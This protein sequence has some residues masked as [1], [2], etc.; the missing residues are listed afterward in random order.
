MRRVGEG[1]PLLRGRLRG[2]YKSRWLS[3]Q[4]GFFGGF[5][6]I[7]LQGSR[8]RGARRPTKVV[9][10]ALCAAKQ[11]WWLT[12]F[13]CPRAHSTQPSQYICNSNSTLP[14]RLES[15]LHTTEQ[16]TV[17]T[18]ILFRRTN[19]GSQRALGHHPP[20]MPFRFYS[21]EIP[22]NVTHG[23]L[24]HWDQEGATYFITWRTAD[25]IPKETWNRWRELRYQWLRQHGIDPSSADWRKRLEELPEAQRRDFRRFAKDLENEIDSCHGA[26]PLRNPA[27]AKIVADT[28]LEPH[29]KSYLLGDFVIMPNHVHLLVG[30]MARDKMLQQVTCRKKWSALQINRLLGRKG[31]LWQ[32]ESFDHLV[33]DL[34]AFERYRRYI[35][36]NPVK[37][38]L[39]AGEY[40]Y[41]KRPEEG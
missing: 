39:R 18:T 36:E 38:R 8:Y 16:K 24:P 4:A 30:G 34:A 41:W 10:T 31:R 3:G 23:H 40:V 19:S 7:L 32:D 27:C 1:F 13:Q 22:I 29:G 11:F 14:E 12:E 20:K 15:S 28:L 17:R 5:D 9:R 25:S 6:S 33:R 2:V 21:P 26:C 37:G 35:A